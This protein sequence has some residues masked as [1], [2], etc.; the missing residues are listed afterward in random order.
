MN[1]KK[2]SKQEDVYYYAAKEA[3][4]DKEFL[5]VIIK[6]F[7]GTV[8]KLLSNPLQTKKGILINTLGK[9]YIKPYTVEKK[10]E[11]SEKNKYFK[12]VEFNNKL[13]KQLNK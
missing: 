5:K 12:K 8:R 7:W 6:N 4:I 10:I 2:Y 11:T 9:F 3:G 1:L 13:L